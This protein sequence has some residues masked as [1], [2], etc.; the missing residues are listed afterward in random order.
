MLTEINSPKS[1]RQNGKKY[2]SKYF[3][4]AVGFFGVLL[5]IIAVSKDIFSPS[6]IIMFVKPFIPFYDGLNIVN[7]TGGIIVSFLWG[8]LLGFF[9]M[10][11]Y[12]WFDKRLT[13]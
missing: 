11:I 12:N 8:W 10:T 3:G 5:F 13:K 1:N 7:F 2:D 4:I 6:N 9:F